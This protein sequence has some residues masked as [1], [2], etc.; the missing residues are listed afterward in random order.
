MVFGDIQ[1]VFVL[2]VFVLLVFVLPVF[3]EQTSLCLMLL[4]L[5]FG[6]LWLKLILFVNV[7]CSGFCET[8]YTVVP[9]YLVIQ[10]LRLQLPVI[11]RG[12]KNNWKIVEINSS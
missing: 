5:I 8:V 9:P 12:L 7:G 6:M 1:F 11:Y 3:E 10:Y 4:I 2:L